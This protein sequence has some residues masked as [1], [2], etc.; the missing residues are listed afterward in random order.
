M[1]AIH[2]KV[3]MIIIPIFL[4]QG[5]VAARLE[6]KEVG[7]A[8]SKSSTPSEIKTAIQTVIDDPK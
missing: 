3:K 5:N 2:H 4:D 8:L 1:E 6:E 7:I